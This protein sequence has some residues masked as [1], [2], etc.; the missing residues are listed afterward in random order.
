MAHLARARLARAY[1][2]KAAQAQKKIDAERITEQAAIHAFNRAAF[3]D[4]LEIENK[5][6]KE[7][8]K[9]DHLKK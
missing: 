3:K 4:W 8:I 6:E 1:L 9:K 2:A 5:G 7:S